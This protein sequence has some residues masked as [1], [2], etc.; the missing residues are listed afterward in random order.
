MIP[1]RW[2][3]LIAI[4]VLGA[5]RLSAAEAAPAAVRVMS[6]NVRN[7]GAHDTINAWVHRRDAFF[8]TVSDF[9]PD[10]IGFQE[11]LADQHDDIVAAMPGYGFAG[12]ARD[13]GK[14]KGE[15]AL[16]GF[17]SARYELLASGDF[18][19]S[20][21]PAVPGSKSWGAG[22]S[23]IC[24][25]TRL[26]DRPTGRE[27]VYANTHLD[28]KSSLARTNGV[29]LIV[30]RLSELAKGLPVLLTGDFNVNEDS[31]AYKAMLHPAEPG[32]LSFVDSY[33]EVHPTRL[34]DEA[35]YHAFK[36][37]T[38]GSRIDFIWHSAAYRATAA[39]I[40]R[41]NIVGKVCPSDHYAVTA[42]LT[43]STE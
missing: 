34:P 43:S 16:L 41:D 33:R 42:I 11:V 9:N 12:V 35:S 18:W 7:S 4:F 23:R 17:R 24:S 21:E 13:D 1:P 40:D 2:R 38:A 26:R 6:F 32:E 19:L 3:T 27:F 22:Y 39:T 5:A 31:S 20:E 28:N 29:R 14:R 30:A 10:L 15:W 8:R 25:W 37:T 36:A